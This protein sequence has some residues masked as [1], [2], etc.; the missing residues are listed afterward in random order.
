M[1]AIA[2][3]LKALDLGTIRDVSTHL[4]ISEKTFETWARDKPELFE[5]VLLGFAEKKRFTKVKQ[6]IRFVK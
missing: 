1:T 5:I 2:E 3:R 6:N 4:R